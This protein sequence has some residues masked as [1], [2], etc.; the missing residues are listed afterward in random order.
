MAAWTLM[1][2]PAW[3]YPEFG[4]GAPTENATTDGIAPLPTG[5]SSK[6]TVT[7]AGPADFGTIGD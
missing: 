7:F 3:M 2:L 5:A 6:N 4:V 1:S